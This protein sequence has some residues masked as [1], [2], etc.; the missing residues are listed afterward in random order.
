MVF[1]QIIINNKSNTNFAGLAILKKELIEANFLNFLD[2][3][4]P[5]HSGFKASEIFSLCVFKNVLDISTYTETAE[6]FEEIS[7]F[8]LK[9]DR[10]TIGRNISKIGNLE[11]YNI[12]LSKFVEDL[13]KKYRVPSTSLRII[14]DETTIEVHKDSKSYEGAS[15]VWDNAQGKLVWGYEVTIIG[16]GYEDL[17]LPIHFEYGKMKKED[18][19]LRFMIIR[20]FTKANIVLFDGGFISDKFFKMLSNSKF[21]FYTKVSKKWIFNN[22][23]NLSVNEIKKN[24]IF[25][26][27]ENFQTRKLFRVKGKNISNVEYNLCFKKDDPRVL[28]TNNLEENISETCFSEFLKRWDIETCNDEIKDNFCFEKL[29]VR[30]KAGITGHILTSLFAYNLVSIIKIKFRKQLGKL[31]NKGFR[32]IIRWFICVKAKWYKYKEKIKIKFSKKFKFKWFFEE[33]DFI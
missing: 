28:L 7:E 8:N 13:L 18:I 26:K 27:N 22:G 29:P 11:N 12:Y 10:T 1:K 5:K 14:I 31:F 25:L 19:H 3:E 20:M 21:I 6:E 4:C 2:K 15:W 16:L 24:I 23:Q 17:F 32:K 30:N 9:I 33:Y